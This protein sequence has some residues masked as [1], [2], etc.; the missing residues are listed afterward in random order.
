[1]DF[2]AARKPQERRA[3]PRIP[4]GV[5]VQIRASGEL[6][7]AELMN[8][9]PSGMFIKPNVGAAKDS[10]RLTALLGPD[11]TLVFRLRLH[12]HPSLYEATGRVAW[13][14]DLGIGI[15]FLE[16]SEPLRAF[17]QQLA[18]AP[19]RAPALLGQIEP[20]PSIDVR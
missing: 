7:A 15:D 13:K 4:C 11:E 3:F 1:M 14:S 5:R 9:S 10:L 16:V 20:D 17:I 19:D 2:L 18:D 12:G 6:V 8:L